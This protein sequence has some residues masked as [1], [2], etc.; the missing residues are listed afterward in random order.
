[1]KSSVTRQDS[2][3]RPGRS[4]RRGQDEPRRGDAVRWGGHRPAGQGRRRIR[5]PRLRREREE[6]ADHHQPGAGHCT[7]NGTKVNIL[8][9]P[10]YADFYGDVKAGLRVADAAIVVL[11]APSGVEVGTELVWQFLE[12]HQPAARDLRQQDGQGA[13]RLQEVSGRRVQQFWARASP[14]VVI[15]IGAADSFKGVIDLIEQKAY[16]T[17][18]SRQVQEGGHPGRHGRRGRRTPDAAHRGRRRDR[19]RS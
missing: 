9:C 5:R 10:G 17:D 16:I 13:R 1:M 6:A 19:T 12:S 15:P 14:P 4:R 8:D 11:A 3:Y 2:Q 7:W 18:E